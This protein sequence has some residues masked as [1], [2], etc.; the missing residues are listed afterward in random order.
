MIHPDS[1]WFFCFQ[2]LWLEYLYNYMLYLA[3]HR[4]W[5]CLF[6]ALVSI[7]F[8]SLCLATHIKHVDCNRTI[9]THFVDDFAAE[10]HSVTAS[11]T[12]QLYTY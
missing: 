2:S 6:Y 7:K 1:T 11:G 9:L 12:V 10:Y 8:L 3:H 5:L 4:V